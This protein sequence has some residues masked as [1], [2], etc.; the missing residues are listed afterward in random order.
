[1]KKVLTTAEFRGYCKGNMLK[2]LLRAN[3]KHDTAD[4]DNKKAAKYAEFLES[5]YPVTVGHTSEQLELF[6][7]EEGN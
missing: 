3:K 6:P 4:A 7:L 2:Y 5:T 1:M